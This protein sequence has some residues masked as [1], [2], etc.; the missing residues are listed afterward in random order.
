MA[1]GDAPGY[2]ISKWKQH[3][4]IM[5]RAIDKVF[6]GTL[7]DKSKSC[8]LHASYL[9]IYNDDIFDLLSPDSDSFRSVNKNIR[10]VE[11]PVTKQVK[12]R[13]IS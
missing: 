2:D 13:G 6:Q 7:K 12:F 1:S 11:D 4:G 3:Q 5:P 8:E 10:I 9:E